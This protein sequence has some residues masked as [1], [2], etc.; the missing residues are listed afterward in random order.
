MPASTRW[1]ALQKR[2]A[3]GRAP[4]RRTYSLIRFSWT[5]FVC[6]HA[7]VPTSMCW[8]VC[9]CI[10]DGM[11]VFLRMYVCVSAAYIPVYLCICREQLVCVCVSVLH[12]SAF[13]R[14][15]SSHSTS[16]RNPQNGFIGDWENTSRYTRVYYK[17]ELERES[18]KIDSIWRD[19]N[20][21]YTFSP[22]VSTEKH[23]NSTL[24][25]PP[26]WLY[27]IFILK[28]YIY[29]VDK[30]GYCRIIPV[31]CSIYNW[32]LYTFLYNMNYD[33]YR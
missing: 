22:R 12:P 32:L 11:C 31:P 25:L 33:R 20:I 29:Y 9:S 6:A 23:V 3:A 10:F 7:S 24:P 26:P 16:W 4:R 21:V 28:Y 30:Y 5:L 13:P 27:F 19:D 18:R 2:S 1:R 14:P 17:K 8:F 15:S